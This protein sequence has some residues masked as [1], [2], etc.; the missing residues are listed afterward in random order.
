MDEVDI[1]RWTEI[2]IGNVDTCRETSYESG[3]IVFH[4]LEVLLEVPF[5]VGSV[6]IVDSADLFDGRVDVVFHHLP[7][8]VEREFQFDFRYGISVT[9]CIDAH[10]AFA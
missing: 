6:E 2:S 5:E 1:C 7:I 3:G 9:S 4:L 10:H 8:V